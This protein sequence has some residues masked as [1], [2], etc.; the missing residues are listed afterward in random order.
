MM[1][2]VICF[3][4]LMIY[5]KSHFINAQQP[6]PSRV[7]TETSRPSEKINTTFPYDIDLKN[8][9]GQTVNSSKLFK[10]NKRATVLLFW[11]TTCGPCR[12]ELNA[13][14]GKFDTWKKKTDFDFYAISIDF[15]DRV[16]QF[17]TRVKESKWPFPAYF[18]INREFRSVMPG[19]LNGLPQLFV[20]NK[21]GEV[22]YHTRRF[23]P[24]DEDKLFEALQKI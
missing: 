5:S 2:A 24:G 7:I 22:I 3:L 15:S 16:E 10:K 19:E 21:K 14:S 17:N 20:L 6:S 9:D 8:A 23:I 18:D 12:M 13:I 11:M 4:I 1:K